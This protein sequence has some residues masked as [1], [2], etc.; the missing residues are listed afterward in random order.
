LGLRDIPLKKAYDS[1]SDD[2]LNDFY[3][4]AL[5]N[6]IH[7][8]RLA[9]FFSSTT[10]AVSAKGII[11][12]I[13]NGGDMKL[14]TGARFR[15]ADIEAIKEAYEQ[16]EKVIEK[17]LI[18]ELDDLENEFIKDHVRAL[19][20]MVAN[21]KLQIK[22]AIIIDED[23]YPIEERI[24]EKRGVFHQK[25]GI[26]EDAEGNIISFSGSENES[27]TGWLN[28]IEEFKVF[29]SWVDAEKD[30]LDADL[31]KFK[32]F[33]S[34]YTK[35]ARVIDIPE[36]VKKRLIEIA[37]DNIEDLNLNKWLQDKKRIKLRN[38]QKEAV[39]SW[40]ISG[41]KGIFEMA[42]GTGKTICALECLNILL[43]TQKPLIT[44]ITVPYIHLVK[45]WAKE[46]E[47]Y[48]IR[49]ERLV[50]NSSNTGWKNRLADRILDIQNGI[51]DALIV[52]TTHTTFASNDFIKLIKK[53]NAKLFLIADEVHGLGA[54]KRKKG[55]IENY[56]FKLGL[57][58]TPKRYYDLEGT[59][60][61]YDYFGDV[62]FEFP[63]KKAIEEGY[64]VPY[65]Y[66]PYFTELT[67]EEM[68]KYEEET[69]KICKAY[70]QTK[71]DKEK[72]RW[73]SLLCFKRQ[74]IIKNA[75]NKYLES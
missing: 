58:A 63:L 24:L 18:K 39:K 66:K 70:H 36:A 38:F 28:N 11:E 10:L 30:Y 52:L 51:S 13:S 73:F 57:S 68:M 53:T 67:E 71:D 75:K 5:S 55:L 27:A 8:N 2:I 74:N 65:D 43:K 46:I 44:V 16:P 17:S 15:K 35:R 72:R 40:L 69:S 3:I 45:Q 33:W 31:E 60:E 64:L 56:M 20:W 12:L 6:S 47:R 59:T 50:A 41:K 9:G 61:L 37:P 54:P 22:V 23:G 1:D 4:P 42:T 19:A 21:G 62:V 26:L 48:G 29:R 14:V 7:Y 25:V 34:G 49:T 32:K